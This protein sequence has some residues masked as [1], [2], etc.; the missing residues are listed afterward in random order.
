MEQ[1]MDL[2]RIGQHAT[3]VNK[4]DLDTAYLILYMVVVASSELIHKLRHDY[5]TKTAKE[6]MTV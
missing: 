1:F 2:G 3:R 6:M 4:R 5:A